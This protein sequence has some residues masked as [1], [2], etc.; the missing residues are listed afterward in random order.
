MK[1]YA[2]SPALLADLNV[3]GSGLPRA[4]VIKRITDAVVKHGFDLA[5]VAH[6]FRE[7]AFEFWTIEAHENNEEHR[8]WYARSANECLVW[9]LA[10]KGLR[11][12][13]EVEERHP[14]GSPT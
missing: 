6:N 11:E 7:A 8:A 2:L 5:A 12:R 9:G 14:G 4:E 1:S 3:L 10:L 13:A